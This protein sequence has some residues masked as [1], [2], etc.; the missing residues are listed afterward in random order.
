MV[1]KSNRIDFFRLL[2]KVGA[3]NTKY[4]NGFQY[5]NKSPFC[6]ATYG[7]YNIQII[8]VMLCCLKH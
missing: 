1:V 7:K 6:I 3:F 5:F 2:L 4:Y 8:N